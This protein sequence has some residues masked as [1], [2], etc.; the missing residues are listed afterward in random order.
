[1]GLREWTGLMWLGLGKISSL[2][3]TWNWIFGFHKRARISWPA[4]WLFASQEVLCST[5]LVLLSGSQALSDY[6]L[7]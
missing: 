1:M 4:G 5:E 2:F 7:M 6:Q 3:W